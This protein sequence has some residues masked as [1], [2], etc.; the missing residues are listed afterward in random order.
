VATT[1]RPLRPWP[2]SIAR[3]SRVKRSSTV[4]R[5][6]S[7]IRELIGEEVHAPHVIASECGPRFTFAAWSRQ[8]GRECVAQSRSVTAIKMP[9]QP[10]VFR[11]VKTFSQNWRFQSVR[12]KSRE[13]CAIDQA[14]PPARDTRLCCADAKGGQQSTTVPARRIARDWAV[15]DSA[16]AHLADHLDPQLEC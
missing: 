10:R 11:S 1:S 2:A 12:S 9:W 14:V 7:S 8:H 6:P 13:W 5:K 15:G 3:H 4:R 16:I